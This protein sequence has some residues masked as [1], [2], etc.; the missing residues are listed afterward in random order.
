MRDE[1]VALM[2]DG[3]R[4]NSSLRR[5][6]LGLNIL[7]DDSLVGIL[8][9]VAEESTPRR[10]SSLEHIELSYN[11]VSFG[12]DAME[13]FERLT[14]S[15]LPKEEDRLLYLHLEGNPFPL[16]K[17]RHICGLEARAADSKRGLRI[18]ATSRVHSK[19]TFEV[20]DEGSEV[21]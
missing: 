21:T 11:L 15:W 2:L 20:G 10:A 7:T 4:V 16:S 14:G 9:A 18:G 5:L 3:L 13:L 1:D 8:E 6:S 12:R 17:E 19:E